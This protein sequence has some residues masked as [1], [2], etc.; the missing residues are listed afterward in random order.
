[1][2]PYVLDENKLPQTFL[3]LPLKIF[4]FF[5]LDPDRYVLEI[6]PIPYCGKN[7]DPDP[8]KTYTDPNT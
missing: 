5:Y 4:L 7:L 8:L 3:L 2:D 6:D 1:M